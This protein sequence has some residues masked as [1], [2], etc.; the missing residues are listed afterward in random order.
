VSVPHFLDTSVLLYSISPDPA[1]A[2]KRDQAV[3]LL[4][5]D[6]GALSVQVLQEFYM[7]ATRPTRPGRLSHQLAIELI[8]AWRRFSV[9][10]M[11]L[12]LLDSAFRIKAAHQMSFWDCAIVAAARA[13]GCRRLYSED[14]TH[15]LAIE[16]V[17]IVN[18]FR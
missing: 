15:D 4:D 8:D 13:L 2:A 10:D 17:R 7:Q 3:A 16:G 12:P 18:P 9:Q 5:Q 14:M 1:E 11:T 6:D